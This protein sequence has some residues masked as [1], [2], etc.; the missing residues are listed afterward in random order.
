MAVIEIPKD[1]EN[2]KDVFDYGFDKSLNRTIETESNSTVYDSIEDR[3]A[4]ASI[5]L[6]GMVAGAGNTMIAIDPSKGLWLGAERF[7]DAPFS[8]D[9]E[10]NA[11]AETLVT[12]QIDIPDT[13]TANSF[14]VDTD[15][16]MWLGATTFAAAPAKVSNA[17]AATF[18]NV[19]ITGGSMSGTP[20]SSIPNNS[21]TDISLLELSHNLTFSSTDSN[22]VAWTSGTITLSNART[23][24]ISAGNTGNMT[25]RT[26]IYLDPGVSSTALQTTT[27][28]STAV[29]ANKRLIAIADVAASG[30]SAYFQVMGGRGGVTID[31][32]HVLTSTLSAITADLGSMTAGT[33]TG[34]TVQTAS[35]GT[36]FVMTS[37]AF[38][39]KNS[40]GT[41]IFEILLTGADAGDVIFGDDATNA[42][43]K[44]DSSA[45]AFVYGSDAA[46]VR[47]TTFSASGTWTKDTG[48]Q[49]VI[50]KAWGGGGSGG[51][52]NDHSATGGG[53]GCYM[54]K[55][56]A[57]A[58][59]GAT[60][61]VTI[62]AGGAGVTNGN[63]GN[64]GGNTTF[65]SHLTAYGGGAGYIVN[66]DTNDYSYSGGEGGTPF[67]AG[68]AGTTDSTTGQAAVPVMGI[69]GQRVV[70]NTGGAGYLSG[71]GGGATLSTATGGGNS[72]KGGAGG[73]GAH[74]GGTEGSGGTSIDG[75]NGGAGQDDTN[76]TAGSARGGGGG[77]CS[78]GGTSGAGGAGYVEVWEF[79]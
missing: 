73:G 62:G 74:N 37:S 49:Y 75:G 10:G 22:T 26:F 7:E 42:Y 66:N 79:Y 43:I 18:S 65:G 67:A 8:V 53:G 36:R 44:Y 23:F 52:Q 21:S 57:A 12:S 61:T 77:A 70:G 41:N 3:I 47:V 11:I 72:V 60:E 55:T 9:M 24:S 20:I 32:D 59:L 19:T 33:V 17:G 68:A 14:H 58:S 50:V 56:I 46:T 27:T 39:G 2:E 38:Q 31:P 13:T 16:N 78:S 15:G 6:G 69:W 30:N 35:S 4:G 76:G 5:S 54:E 64:V 28:F 71:A 1:D 40:S 34:A 29:G 48:L 45:A 25:T 63:P 51:S